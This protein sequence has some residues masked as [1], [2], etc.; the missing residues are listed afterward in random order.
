MIGHCH[1]C[2]ANLWAGEDHKDYCQYRVGVIS[3]HTEINPKFG[4]ITKLKLEL[5][6]LEA[7]NA[8]LKTELEK[9]KCCGNCAIIDPENVQCIQCRNYS[10]WQLKED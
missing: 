3:E 4:I 2:G 8:A 9:M 5:E 6:Q 10:N 7:E 1:I